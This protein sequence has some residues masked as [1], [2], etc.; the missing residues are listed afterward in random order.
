MF[1]PFISNVSCFFLTTSKTDREQMSY[2]EQS[3][4]LAGTI[5]LLKQ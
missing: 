4:K 5:A 3:D 1:V 2:A